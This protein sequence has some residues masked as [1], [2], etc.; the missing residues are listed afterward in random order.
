M[1]GILRLIF[2]FAAVVAARLPARTIARLAT[3]LFSKTARQLESAAHDVEGAQ[4]QRLRTQL[5]RAKDTDFGR[6]HG[7]AAILAAPDL[8]TAYRAAV[9]LQTWDDVSPWVERMVAGESNVLTPEDVF[10]YA[11]T[12]GTTGHRKLIPVTSAFIE[13]ARVTTRVLA[14]TTLTQIPGAVQGKRL[15]MRSPGVEELRPGV[16]AGSITVALAG[17]IPG[18]NEVDD[19]KGA[20]DALPPA[21][22]E[23][24]D[25]RTRY[26][27]C[28]RLAA[29]EDVRLV[30]AI[31]PSTLL[32]FAQTLAERG[33]E[34]AA[35]LEQGTLGADL[36]LDAKLRG[37]LTPFAKKDA[38]AAARIRESAARHGVAR[39]ADLFANLAGL[40]CWK[41]GSAP[42]YVARLPQSYGPVPVLDYGY[43]ASEGVFGAPL[44][45]DGAAS[46]IFPHGHFYEFFLEDDVEHAHPKGL[47]QLQKG[48]RV[49]VV[50]TTGAGLFR[51]QMF[52]IV[53][54]VGHTRTAAIGTDVDGIP[55]VIFRQ[56]AGAMASVTGEKLG[57][58]HVVA[59]MNRLHQ[60]AHPLSSKILGLC[61][62]PLLPS[63][64]E[65]EA[66]TP[67]YA[68]ALDL[69]HDA[70]DK[71]L[72]SFAIAFDG[73]LAVENLEYDAKRNSLR[74]APAVAVRLP[75]RAFAAHRA[76]R[77]AQGAPDA[78]VKIPHVSADGGLL[79]RLGLGDS[80]PAIAAM[81]P[82]RRATEEDQ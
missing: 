15:Q 33:E 82:C 74:I 57:E 36:V 39:M 32:L 10:F 70:T 12:S 19:D 69:A 41:G 9:P 77:V 62:A 37:R 63:V 34:I 30:S 18:A 79:L 5:E 50:V 53:E 27:L 72:E 40:V 65:G 26:F 24:E 46:G 44:S 22:F 56:K 4:R 49:E 64:G 14:R 6:R 16:Y 47:H 28:I 45:T 31:N 66:L 80:A 7:F 76:E 71:D 42:W 68:I 51:Y 23:I 48:Q 1:N 11:T 38:A 29:S 8:V 13:E 17:T 73:A 67:R 35:A 52:D 21:V 43:A 3:I 2:R 59:A 81:L 75:P 58:A 25:F 20:L 54:V 78:H 55:L 60:D 61:V